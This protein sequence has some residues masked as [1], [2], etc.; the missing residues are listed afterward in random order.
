MKGK[1]MN[2]VNIKRNEDPKDLMTF[3]QLINEHGFTYSYLYKKAC[4]ECV[5]PI[6]PRGKL[7]LSERDVLEYEKRKAGK[8]GKYSQANTHN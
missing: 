4:I 2:V 5:I 7:K 1:I 6:Y 3:A 8:Y